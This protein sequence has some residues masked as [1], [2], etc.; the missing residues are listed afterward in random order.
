MMAA[1]DNFASI[2]R[3]AK[4]LEARLES[5][6]QSY[7]SLAQRINADLICDEEN[8]LIDSNEEQSLANEIERD[9][10]ELQDLL[11]NMRTVVQEN[12]NPSGGHEEVL[13]KR[14]QEI[15]FDY[16][17][18]FKKT[19]T[20][21]TR[22][23]ESMD[24]FANTN[25]LSNSRNGGNGSS[26]DKDSATDKLLRER[27]SIASSMRSINEV[28]AQAFDAK[29]SLLGQRSTL[30]GATTGLSTITSNVPSLSRLIDGISRKKYRESLIVALFISV[31]L[32][33]TIW[34]MFLR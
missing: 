5:R 2:H 23:R 10:S 11:G 3:L 25:K 14:Y 31:L 29:N 33:F 18:E 28:I 12:P 4:L 19:S 6:V 30:G 17:T 22:K 34:W 24:L 1:K 20:T 13:I 9:L 7:S 16:S 32:C 8:S 26:Q 15:H 27:N 21:V